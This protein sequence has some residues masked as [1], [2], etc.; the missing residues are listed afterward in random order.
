[1]PRPATL[2]FTVL[3]GKGKSSQFLLNLPD[4]TAQ[5]TMSV[6][7]DMAY[8]LQTLVD[9]IIDG[10]IV[11]CS[12][13]F[14]VPLDPT[15]KSVPGA[16]SDVEQQAEFSFESSTGFNTQTN[17]PAVLD[18]IFV[19]ASPIVDLSNGDVQDFVQAVLSGLNGE[20]VVDTRGDDITTL[21]NA[22]KSFCRS[23]V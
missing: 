22:L 16:N 20:N 15:L 7:L 9:E 2:V 19:L 3:D 8:Q 13:I 18:S 23:R 21:N 1:M 12:V 10:Q 17:I 14:D 5:P 6:Q 11:R 4:Q